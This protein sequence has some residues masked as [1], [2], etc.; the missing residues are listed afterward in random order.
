MSAVLRLRSRRHLEGS[1][2]SATEP[3]L[4]TVGR[5]YIGA[6]YSACIAEY[7]RMREAKAEDGKRREAERR[8]ARCAQMLS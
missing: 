7:A 6:T 2:A 5:R 3:R 1:A 8:A 4:A